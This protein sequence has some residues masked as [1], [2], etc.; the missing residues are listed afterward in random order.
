MTPAIIIIADLRFQNGVLLNWH[1]YSSLSEEG[2]VVRRHIGEVVEYDKHFDNRLI[3][4]EQGKLE[5]IDIA[6]VHPMTI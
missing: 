4:I 2:L 5:E 1:V 6:Q 3:R